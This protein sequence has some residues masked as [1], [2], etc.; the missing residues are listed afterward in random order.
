MTTDQNAGRWFVI[1]A[2][3]I[4][5]AMVIAVTVRAFEMWSNA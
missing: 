3:A 4:A 5:I 2:T 1:G